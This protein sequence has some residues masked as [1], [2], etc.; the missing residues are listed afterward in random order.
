M[1]IYTI[2]IYDMSL[3]TSKH[4]WNIVLYVFHLRVD[5]TAQSEALSL[6]MYLSPSLSL[7]LFLFT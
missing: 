4:I 5:P 3:R 1:Y 6:Y 7:L 2:Y